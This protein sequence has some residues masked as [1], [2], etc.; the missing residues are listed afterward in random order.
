MITP[1]PPV[2]APPLHLLDFA[3]V[4][5][6]SPG[7]T[8]APAPNTSFSV[9]RSPSFNPTPPP[10]P[11][12]SLLVPAAAAGPTTSLSASSSSSA[13]HVHGDHHGHAFDIPQQMWERL[14]L[15]DFSERIDRGPNLLM[16]VF[17]LPQLIM[18]RRTEECWENQRKLPILGW[19]GRLLPTDRSSWS[20]EKGQ[21]NVTKDH[22]EKESAHWVWEHDWQLTLTPPK[23]LPL[24]HAV[25]ASSPA[26]TAGIASATAAAAS[27]SST[28]PSSL[29]SPP[30]NG[31]GSSRSS[32]EDD[33]EKE[34]E[35]ITP[36][37]PNE[38]YLTDK[39]G[40]MY[41]TDFQA[42]QWF[43]ASWKLALVRRR[44]WT[45]TRVYVKN[46][47]A[48]GIPA[49]KSHHKKLAPASNRGGGSTGNY[50]PTTVITIQP[51][52][53]YAYLFSYVTGATPPTSARTARQGST[54]APMVHSLGGQTVQTPT[55][56]PGSAPPT[57]AGGSVA[58]A[59]AAA[60]SSSSTQPLSSISS[61]TT[62]NGSDGVSSPPAGSGMI[63]A[64]GS[65]PGIKKQP[66]KPVC[67][68]RS[69]PLPYLNWSYS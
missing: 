60:S 34:D 15:F 33:D 38:T 39:D 57:P 58:Q 54:S 3:T 21:H 48:D 10:N 56:N 50:K 40:W 26:G 13:S 9:G 19:T 59:F 67:T 24:A 29:S 68:V 22:W 11:P 52:L 37:T 64:P 62:M 32:T 55:S 2:V 43:P 4:A 45:R 31:D 17:S 16:R 30:P 28:T 63:A 42:R 5:T 46:I 35:P 1:T 49:P 12:P 66:K 61:S 20:D 41:A 27:L 8:S 18:G 65:N 6:S 44:R 23:L 53:T 51:T 36:I 69:H 7:A 25:V 47:L 14:S